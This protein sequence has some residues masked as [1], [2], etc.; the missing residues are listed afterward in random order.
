MPSNTKPVLYV[1]T[2]D[3]NCEGSIKK[4]RDNSASGEKFSITAKVQRDFNKRLMSRGQF[5]MDFNN[6]DLFSKVRKHL[7]HYLTDKKCIT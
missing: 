2:L 4:K 5:W 1:I 3:T 6:F 7:L